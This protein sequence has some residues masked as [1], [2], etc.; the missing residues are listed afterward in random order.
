MFTMQVRPAWR[1]K[2]NLELQYRECNYDCQHSIFSTYIETLLQ[3]DFIN[4]T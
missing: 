3:F 1:I 2:E 4:L